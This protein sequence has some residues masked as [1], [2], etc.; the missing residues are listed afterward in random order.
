[1]TTDT[2]LSHRSVSGKQWRMRAVD[3]RAALALSQREG[4][5]DIVARILTGRGIGLEDSAKFLEPTLRD[6][7]PDPGHLKDMDQAVARIIAAVETGETIAIFG[8]YDVDGATSSALLQRYFTALSAKTRI[9][10]PDRMAE[11]YGPNAPALERLAREGATL[12]ITVDCGTLAFDALE[13]AANA[14]LEM[15]VVDH[16]Q[17][18]PRLPKA[19]AVVN[20]NRLDEDSPVTHL[21]AV[22]LAFLLTVAV[23]RGLREA[24]WFTQKQMREPDLLSLL[25]LVALGTVCDVVSL[26]GL[27][28]AFVAQGLRV[29][30]G[31]RNVGLNALAD[32]AKM[33]SVPE[34]YHLGFI[35]GPRVNA[36]GR[37]GQSDLGATLLATE[38]RAEALEIAK[39]LD[40][41]NTERKAIEADVQ[42]QAIAEV[43]RMADAKGTLPSAIV[44]AGEGWHPGVI[45]IV[46]GRLKERYDR[47]SLVIGFPD[48]YQQPG[49]GSGRSLTGIDLGSAIIAAHQ[50]ELLL[51]GG[52][53]AM[54]AGLTIAADQVDAF[55]AFLIARVDKVVAE[56]L[57]APSLTLDA[58]LS[59]SG[60][61]LELVETLSR[62]APFGMG[63]P[64]P[65]FLL[66]GGRV[67][68][69][70][71]VGTDHV[72]FTVQGRETGSKATGG[73]ATR[74]KGIAF[75][76]ADEP[77]GQALLNAKGRS[78]A[79]AGT[80]RLDEW[81]G[82][83]EVKLHLEDA[84]EIGAEDMSG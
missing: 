32:V 10:I 12:A 68:H 46:A 75:R 62:L 59:P 30:A 6:W 24:G 31:R 72:R 28:R 55:R 22:G 50:A 84:A 7:M 38:N 67:T 77:L 2:L 20:P 11:G 25:D 27:N 35:L 78:L 1:M 33:E 13:A 42:E 64:Q 80:I 65:R 52:G 4:L 79:L 54:A 40:V 69:A 17:A 23:N 66:T 71:I 57:G 21:A 58:A 45:G 29:M 73:A 19:A 60:A 16:H 39:R 74:L 14:G 36:G 15:I 43:E 81:Q 63:N 3:E 8:D 61:T 47:P 26:T 56:G 37:V 53:H 51:A 5:P 48:G 76:V 34:A 44:V 70:D 83:R 82:R 49:K 9:Y 18:E 41:F